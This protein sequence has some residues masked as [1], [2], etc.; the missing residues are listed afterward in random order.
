[1]ISAIFKIMWLRL[2]RDK[3]ALVLAFLLPG[4]IF[5]VFAAIFSNA[6]GGSLELRVAMDLQS[7]APA[8]VRFMEAVEAEATFTIVTS[9]MPVI[10]Q[11]RLGQ[12]DVGVIISGDMAQLSNAPLTIIKDPS[13]DVAATVIKGQL[14]QI[15]A[16]QIGADAPELFVEKNAL[17]DTNE[18]TVSDQSV[19]YYIGGTAILFL[20]FSAMQGA[21]LSIEERRNGISDRLMVGAGGALAM[22]TGKFLFLTMIGFIQ[23]ALIVAV[24]HVFF[25]V[26]ILQALPALGLACLGSAMIAAALAL[27]TA[28]L[29]STTSQMHTVSTFVVLLFSAIGGSMV[30]RFMMPSWLQDI[31]Q[32]TPNHWAIEAFYG[33]LARGQNIAELFVVWCVLFGGAVIALILAAVVSHKMMRV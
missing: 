9:D 28:A 33:I 16:K 7:D 1:M 24:A 19:T 4:F 31:G 6:S 15:F 3:G 23:A 11:V 29:C 17:P 10:E 27:L 2:W 25:A 32:F 26:P 12:A 18:S 22:L 5:A 21:A 30:P 8:S 20:L 13:R 14:R